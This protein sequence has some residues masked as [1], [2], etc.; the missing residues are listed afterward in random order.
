MTDALSDEADLPN[1]RVNRVHK[2]DLGDRAERI[3]KD[4]TDTPAFLR[5][6]MD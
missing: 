1:G 3:N 5:K 4:S 2:E 6:M